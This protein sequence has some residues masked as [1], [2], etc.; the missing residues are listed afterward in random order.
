MSCCISYRFKF[1]FSLTLFYIYLLGWSKVRFS[2]MRRSLW[3]R[4]TL[5]IT[6]SKADTRHDKSH[7]IMSRHLT[8]CHVTWCHVMQMYLKYYLI[9]SWRHD[10]SCHV[11]QMDMY[12]K[13]YL[14]RSWHTCETGCDGKTSIFTSKWKWLKVNAAPALHMSFTQLTSS[15]SVMPGCHSVTSQD[16]MPLCHMMLHHGQR[17]HSMTLK[18]E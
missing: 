17:V 10:M 7:Y 2:W 11:I 5:N 6:S 14:I 1:C 16:D 18:L 13:Y 9:K 12:F 15:C 4:C 3:C 8:L